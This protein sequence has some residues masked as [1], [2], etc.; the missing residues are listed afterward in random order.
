ML[1]R[2]T[3]K[4]AGPT[5]R[6]LPAGVADAAFSSVATLICGIVAVRRLGAEPLGVYA[7]F[8]GAFLVAGVVPTTLVFTPAQVAV[9]AEE[10][11]RHLRYLVPVM[12]HGLFV[13]GVASLLACGV[14]ALFTGGSGADVVIPLGATAL[15]A[16][17]ISPLQDF[18]RRMLHQAGFSWTAV[19]IAVAQLTVVL[20]IVGTMLVVGVPPVWIPFTALGTAN[21]LSGALALVLIR[22]RG[23]LRD[24]GTIGPAALIRSGKWL[25]IQGLSQYGMW[26]AAVA[27][28]TALASH[29]DAGYAEAARVL[30]QPPVVLAMGLMSVIGPRIMG[31]TQAADWGRARRLRR[32]YAAVLVAAS[33]G[34]A[35]VVGIAWPFNPL[36]T[37]FAPAYVTRGLVAAMILGQTSVWLAMIVANQAISAREERNV[38]RAGILAAVV[39]AIVTL[40]LGHWGALAIPAGLV[41]YAA[42]LGARLEPVVRRLQGTP[43]PS[44]AA[45]S[46]APIPGV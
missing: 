6:R 38:A 36:V 44:D 31:A 16:S 33:C 29:Q 18:V 24:R 22:R 39:Q 27:I 1:S 43:A 40:A 13:A 3:G 26:F 15:A 11:H 10:P 32:G 45:A 41:A 34:Y 9:L 12:R 19:V 28:V 8:N 17:V 2:L 25:L 23:H 42:V 46:E 7:L 5:A 4:Q 35:F 37:W 14:A 20:G 21:L 30:A